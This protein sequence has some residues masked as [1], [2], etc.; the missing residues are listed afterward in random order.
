MTAQLPAKYRRYVLLSCCRG[1]FNTSPD[2][3]RLFFS[4]AAQARKTSGAKLAVT[5][6]VTA[7]RG[8]LGAKLQPSSIQ[9]RLDSSDWRYSSSTSVALRALF[10]LPHH[11]TLF[12]FFFF[13]SFFSFF[14]P[15]LFT[16]FLSVFL[17]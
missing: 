10:A 1:P 11:H 3:A 8:L 9:P 13:F 15:S 6:T 17:S 7:G 14:F 16:S 12:F 5:A 2:G 4:P